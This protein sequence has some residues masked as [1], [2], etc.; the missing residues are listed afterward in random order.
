MGEEWGVEEVGKEPTRVRSQGRCSSGVHIATSLNHSVHGFER[1]FF[2]DPEE[3][4]HG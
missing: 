4:V 1:P 3:L 2:L